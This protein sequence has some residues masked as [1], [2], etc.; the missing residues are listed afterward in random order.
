[1]VFETGGGRPK[2]STSCEWAWIVV[3]DYVNAPNGTAGIEWQKVA[4]VVDGPRV[5]P[6]PL[7]RG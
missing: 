1:M 6:P 3:D 4:D 5:G 7:F 2:S